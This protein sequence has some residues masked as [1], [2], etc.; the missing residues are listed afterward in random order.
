MLPEFRV[1]GIA[2][3]ASAPSP[4]QALTDSDS[5]SYS[6]SVRRSWY[7]SGA[8][9]RGRSWNR[10]SNAATPKRWLLRRL[11]P[12]PFSVFCP[13]RQC[14]AGG[15]RP[16]WRFETK[17]RRAYRKKQRIAL[18]DY[19]RLVVRFWI[20]GKKITTFWGVKG[21]IF[22]KTAIIQL[23]IIIFQKLLIVATCSFHQRVPRS[24]LINIAYR[25][26]F[27]MEYM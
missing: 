18:E 8:W 19:S 27:W 11:N 6:Y 10:S 17:R 3:P 26:S 5:V 25:Y 24:I 16:P 1:C 4:Y 15:V 2:A 23:Y 7:R 9:I 20:L 21:Q 22:A 14:R 13:L 12:R